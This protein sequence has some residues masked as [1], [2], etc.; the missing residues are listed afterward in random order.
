[1]A[2]G[3]KV[4]FASACTLALLL[5]L[6]VGAIN[7]FALSAQLLPPP[8][9][10]LAALPDGWVGGSFWPHIA[11]TLQ[12]SLGG[13]VIGIV[14]GL[15][16]GVVVAEWRIARLVFYPIVI[17]IQSMPT[18]AIAPLVIVYFGVGL[19]SKLV[20]VALLC[21]FP[22]FVNTVAGLTSAN[23]RLLDLYRAASAT[24][25]RTLVDIKLPGA[26][27]HILASVQIALVLSFI[28]CVVSEFIASRAGLG[29]LIKIYS[30]DINVA[31][32][33]AAIVSLAVIGGG[34]G[35]LVTLARRRIVF[36][37]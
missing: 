6:W 34:L 18:V 22:V 32:M 19:P 5:L 16:A 2:E 15:V 26:A 7:A 23:G 28:G 29:H 14:I 37:Q 25:W 21:C 1:M 8:S 3:I 31:V 9:S 35:Y 33:F 27:E 10:V 17:G 24:R 11:F 4:V 13:W 30:S 36:W 12:G 20:T